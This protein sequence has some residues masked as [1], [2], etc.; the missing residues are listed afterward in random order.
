MKWKNKR[1]GFALY[2]AVIALMVTI[3]TLGILQQSLLLLKSIQNTTFRD[4]LRWHITQEKLQTDLKDS[5]IVSYDSS[6]IIFIDPKDNKKR[7]IETYRNGN[8]DY[9]LRIRFAD[10]R[11]QEPIMTNLRKIKI[12]KFPNLV[13]I[14]TVNSNKQTSEMYLTFADGN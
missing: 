11:G 9:T 13:M 2:E 1:D 3:M 12:E 6:K 14:T 8:N 10:Q 5:Q 4:Q 7:V